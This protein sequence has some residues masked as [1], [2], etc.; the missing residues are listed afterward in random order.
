M[1]EIISNDSKKFDTK[2]LMIAGGVLVV[3][4]L[5]AF[6]QLG[7]DNS[8]VTGN[9][10][11]QTGEALKNTNTEYDGNTK[12]VDPEVKEEKEVKIKSNRVKAE[13]ENKTNIEA[14]PVDQQYIKEGDNFDPKQILKEENV[15]CVTSEY[16]SMG[17]HCKT[18]LDKDGFDKNGFDKN[19]F[20]KD[21]CNAE[22]VDI[23]GKACGSFLTQK[24]SECLNK[25]IADCEISKYDESGYDIDGYDRQGF[26]RQ[27]FNRDGCDK[28]G[29]DKDGYSCETK[30][31]RNGF[32]R[33][34]CDVNG[35]DKDAYHCETKLNKNGLDREGYDKDGFNKDGCNREGFT[36]EAK[37]CKGKITG[38]KLSAEEKI[39]Y[40]NVL[41]NKNIFFAKIDKE[42]KEYTMD[43]TSKNETEFTS[44]VAPVIPSPSENGSENSSDPDAKPS[45][46]IENDSNIEIPTGAMLYGS[47]QANMNSDY[48]GLVRVKVLGGPLDQSLLMGEYTVPF[49]EDPYRPRDKIR[50]T[51]TQLVFNR[52]S[53]PIN[54]VALDTKSMTDYISG[55]V[56]Y[57][58]V[59]R[60]GGL[61][62]ANV[63]KGIGKAVAT[64]G[65]TPSNDGSGLVYQ[66]PI[67]ATGDQLKVAAGE[68]GAELSSMARQQFDRPPTIT[69][70][71]GEMIA[72]FFM[73]ELNDDRV[74][75][76]FNSK[77]MQEINQK[78]MMNPT[79]K[80]IKN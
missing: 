72:I 10:S 12:E 45:E 46:T 26:D 15:P 68:V 44:Y 5:I 17:F 73:Q 21:G 78:L 69:K 71:Q 1:A 37:T 74:P 34:G 3:V 43:I 32:D 80:N 35:Y 67:T 49:I 6:W 62:A 33:N 59:T 36:K 18:G 51:L 63:L 20:G 61:I 28:Q 76:I 19:G 60:W 23:S 79:N 47:I 4:L 55:E 53:I 39:W 38:V 41:G 58:Y 9:I 31:N 14:I 52:N 25:L 50:M 75:M 40:D 42:T 66:Q 27:G 22:G 70:S 57:H 30:L 64:G 7:N 77:E 56:D 13:K 54:A 16:D 11:D 48:P 8:E 29:Y 24:N 2:K 65:T